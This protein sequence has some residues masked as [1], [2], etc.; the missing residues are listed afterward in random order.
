MLI[1][2]RVVT[3]DWAEASVRNGVPVAI[4]VGER[5]KHRLQIFRVRGGGGPRSRRR[6]WARNTKVEGLDRTWEGLTF[7]VL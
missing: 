5:F 4:E 7:A 6:S 1:L 2:L 3:R